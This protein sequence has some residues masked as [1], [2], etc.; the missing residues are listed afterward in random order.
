MHEFHKLMYNSIHCLILF[1]ALIIMNS[2]FGCH[3]YICTC[4]LIVKQFNLAVFQ[5]LRFC[6]QYA[7]HTTLFQEVNFDGRESNNAKH[8]VMHSISEHQFYQSTQQ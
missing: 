6:Y 8:S 3:H 2:L 1:A 5:L 7:S 4:G